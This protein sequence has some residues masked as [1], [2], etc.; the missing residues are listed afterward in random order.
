[1]CIIINVSISK[2]ENR[3]E[4]SDLSK[5]VL[6]DNARIEQDFK[7]RSEPDGFNLAVSMTNSEWV[8]HFCD[9]DDFIPDAVFLLNTLVRNGNFKD[10]DVIFFKCVVDGAHWGSDRV[11]LGEMISAN[12]IPYAS[13]VRKSVWD[14]V[15]GYK[16]EIYGDWNLWI[17]LL[18]AGK[19]FVYYPDPIFNFTLNGEGY[20]M[21]KVHELGRGECERLA[22][23]TV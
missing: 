1:M 7:D 8:C 3:S 23:E 4:N 18:K 11:S 16:C 19:K 6:P 12:S 17:R 2:I 21:R 5:I 13:Y 20:S 22:R 10:H 9:D 14:E 15:G